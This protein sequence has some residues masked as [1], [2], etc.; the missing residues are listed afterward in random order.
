[1]L[2]TRSRTAEREPQ[3]R[4]AVAQLLG[5]L[6]AVAPL[7]VA[8][9]NQIRIGRRIRGGR[10]L[11]LQQL[12]DALDAERPTD[13]GRLAATELRDEPVVAAARTYGALRAE[14]V[15]DPLEDGT[16]I[17]VETAH[18]PRIQREAHAD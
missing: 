12:D 15:G 9:R 17:V 10:S 14:L 5:E 3:P 2:E 4:Y 1:R 11:R 16:R 6:E 7:R 18:E 8:G 13:G